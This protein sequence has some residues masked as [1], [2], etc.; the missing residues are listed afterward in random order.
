[1]SE[2]KYAGTE[3][4]LFQEALNWKK[5]WAS[6]IHKYL[7][8]EVLEVGAGLGQN[9]L[10]LRNRNVQRWV[11]LE[12]DHI[13]CNRIHDT[14]KSHPRVK[15]YE[16]FEGT[17][18]DLHPQQL[19]DVIIYI[20]VM[21]HIRDDRNEMKTAAQHLKKD[22]RLIVLSPAHQWLFTDFDLAIGHYRR[23]N[24]KTLLSIAAGVLTLERMFYLDSVGFF[25]SFANRFF[26]KQS[27]PTLKQIRF[28]DKVVVRCSRVMDFI[29][30]YKIGK[31]IMGIWRKTK[32]EF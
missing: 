12:P 14:F 1:M 22:G 30:F 28:W 10:L 16:V 24:K 29:L 8:G 7:L 17:L 3:L 9:T 20:D 11:C 32:T 31:S 21:E 15:Q 19:F 18:S 27:M 23:Y 2:F 6:F 25:A 5:Y 26:L 4:D 13:L